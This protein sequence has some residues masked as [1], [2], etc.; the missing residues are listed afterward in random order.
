M[1]M[2]FTKKYFLLFVFT[3]SCAGILAEDKVPLGIHYQAVA[4]DNFGNELVNK[5]ISVR[6]SIISGN[7]LGTVV[8]QELHQD[9][10]TSRSGVFSLIIG[11]GT[12]T[13]NTPCGE[14]SQI[15]WESAF[16]FLK[17]EVKFEN[18]FMD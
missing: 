3:M 11:H 14:L 6:F 7:P 2:R 16:H 1:D 13:G 17:V 12:P 4:R 10:L 8:Y 5:K 9:I 15:S 18:E